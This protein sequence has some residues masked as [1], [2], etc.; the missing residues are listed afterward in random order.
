MKTKFLVASA[1]VLASY[2]SVN[3]NL[4]RNDLN[5][6]TNQILTV[7]QVGN[8]KFKVLIANSQNQLTKIQILD[9]NGNEIYNEKQITDKLNAKLFD[10]SNLS[11][12]TYT[13]VVQ[14][15]D[16]IE[17]QKVNIIT[18]TNRSALIA[19]N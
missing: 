9:A 17:K 13:F 2:G 1:I 4:L 15:G 18:Q 12:G 16:T 8:L 3:A 6:D 19:A 7:K 5:D 10:L 11:D 14:K